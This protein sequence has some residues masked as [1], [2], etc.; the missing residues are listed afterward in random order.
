MFNINIQEY[1]SLL[2][3]IKFTHTQ[4]GTFDYSNEPRPCYYF[5]FMLE[6]EGYIE[7]NGATIPLKARD[8]LLIPKNTTYIS[9]WL[10]NP[11]VVFHSLHFSFSPRNDPFFNVN[12]PIQLCPNENFDEL[13]THLKKIEKH[14]TAKDIHA[15][16]ALSSFYAICEQ[17][18]QSVTLLP[19]KQIDKRIS[20]A[21]QYIEHN[22]SSQVSV[23]YLA[24]LCFISAPRF[25]YLFK[26]Q[27]GV[28]PI[29]YKNRLAIQQAAQELLL[30]NNESIAIIAERHGFSSLIYFER[31]FKKFIGK[32]PSLYRK[33]NASL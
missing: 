29:V 11:K 1:F 6:G 24:S 3:A 32:S 23:D 2:N 25:Y 7:T 12:M 10:P 28:S 30:N 5:L 19:S 14:Q 33:E 13:Y 8:I 27:T 9:H 17:V 15:F 21:I 18:F 16:T 31:L 26:K 4:N 22:Y 20:P